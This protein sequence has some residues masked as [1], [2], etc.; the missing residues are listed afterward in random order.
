MFRVC[1][2]D[3]HIYTHLILALGIVTEPTLWGFITSQYHDMHDIGLPT[4]WRAVLTAQFVW[5]QQLMADC[6]AQLPEVCPA[7]LVL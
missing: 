6:W 7:S 5:A 4:V 1:A 2:R 3:Y